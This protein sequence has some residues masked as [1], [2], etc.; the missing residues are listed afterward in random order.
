MAEKNY[1]DYNRSGTFS[2]D[3]FHRMALLMPEKFEL[4]TTLMPEVRIDD[5][6]VQ[7]QAVTAIDEHEASR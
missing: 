2:V 6:V 7:A 3:D 1:L 5:E 4:H